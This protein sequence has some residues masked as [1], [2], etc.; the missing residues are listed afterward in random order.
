MKLQICGVLIALSIST[1]FV[2]IAQ[3]QTPTP[4]PSPRPTIQVE[5]ETS[6]VCEHIVDADGK[7]LYMFDQD[8]TDESKCVDACAADFLPFVLTAEDQPAIVTP[9]QED[10][11][12]DPV[13]RADEQRQ[14]VYGGHPLY[15]FK[16]D[17]KPGQIEGHCRD[18]FGGK[19]YLIQPDGTACG[20]EQPAPPPAPA[21][22]YTSPP[23]YSPSCGSY[24]VCGWTPGWRC[25]DPFP[26][27]SQCRPECCEFVNDFTCGGSDFCG[28]GGGYGC[29]SQ[30]ACGWTPG[31]RCYLPE[32]G[33]APFDRSCLSRC[34]CFDADD[35]SCPGFG[36]SE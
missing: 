11:L 23:S 31:W 17:K 19:W 3:A 35:F 1:G 10:L 8:P 14:I 9:A 28:G 18:L 7:S 5:P 15:T 33:C 36:L 22:R 20:C 30:T 12:D 13:T 32:G 6:D 25:F 4:S 16:S 21:P 24:D 27:L 34:T 2:S 26:Q 29:T